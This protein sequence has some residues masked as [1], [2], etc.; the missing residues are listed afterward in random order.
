MVS[1]VLE[2][3]KKSVMDIE[4]SAQIIL[5][6]SRARGDFSEASDWDV[7][8]L[9]E[10]DVDYKRTDKIRHQLHLIEWDTGDVISSIVRNCTV[11][12]SP[13]YQVMP[14]HKSIETDGIRL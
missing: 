6:G 7:L 4:P 8:I 10:G 9:V 11:W 12:E 5:Y 2:R 13:Q 1:P 3:V 14:L